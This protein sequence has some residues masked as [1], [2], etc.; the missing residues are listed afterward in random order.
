MG[1]EIFKIILIVLLTAALAVLIV[2]FFVGFT[3]VHLHRRG[4]EGQIKAAMVGDSITY[5]CGVAGW[6]WNNYPAVLQKKLGNGWHV[7]NFAVSDHTLQNTGDHPYRKR[8][9]FR[10]SQDFN[11][12]IVCIMIGTN[13]AK[14][15]NWIDEDAFRKSYEEMIDTYA[16]LPSHPE[17]ILCRPAS[18]Y[19][20]DETVSEGPYSYGIEEKNLQK[21]C[22]AVDALGKERELEVADMRAATAGHREWYI[23]DG[24]HPNSRGAAVLADTMYGV[25]MKGREN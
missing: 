21:I 16:A 2:F 23:F 1:G 4:K 13:D 10:Q 18:A 9:E 20:K 12:D 22:A 6:P 19:Y 17:I 11:P 8:K 7:E 3:N 25:L 15:I 24:I 14:D 5:G